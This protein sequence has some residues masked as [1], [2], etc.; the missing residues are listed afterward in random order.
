MN[1]VKSIQ[2][3]IRV[4]E[5][6]VKGLSPDS[7]LREKAFELVLKSLLQK[8]TYSGKKLP[9]AFAG[10]KKVSRTKAKQKVSEKKESELKLDESELQKLKVFYNKFQPT[11]GERCVFVLANFLRLKLS[12]DGFHEGDV[13]YCYQKLLNLRTKNLPPMTSTQIKRNLNWLVAPSRKKQWLLVNSEGLY[14][15][16]PEGIITFNGMIGEDDKEDKL[17]K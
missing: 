1:K 6:S 14:E 3:K 2:E 13:E 10:K 17:K 12:K 7:A 15:M 11:G 4:A 5:E 16:S 9:S 8:T